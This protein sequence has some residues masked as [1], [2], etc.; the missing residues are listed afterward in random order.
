MSAHAPHSPATTSPQRTVITGLGVLCGVGIGLEPVWDG[1]VNGR[2]GIHPLHGAEFD[3]VAVKIGGTV[4]GFDPAPWIDPKEMR[5]VDAG[6]VYGLAAAQMAW[7]DAGL[8]Q[9]AAR[10]RWNPDRAGVAW[11]TAIGGIEWLERSVIDRVHGRRLSPF[12]VAGILPNMTAGN[13]SI[14]LGLRGPSICQATACAASSHA[15]GLAR[16]MINAGIADVMVVGGAEKVATPL[17]IAA[18]AAMRALSQRN[19]DPGRA[20]RPWDRGRDGFV[21]GDGGAVLILESEAHAR[22]RGARIYAELVGFGLSSDAH[23]ITSP[24]SDGVGAARAMRMALD[25]AH[26]PAEAIDYVNAH[27]TST[28]VGDLAEVAG[29]KAVFGHRARHTPVSSTKSMTGHLLGASGALEAVFSVLA[30]CR[31]VLP[32]TINLDQPDDGCDLDF[33]PHAARDKRVRRVLSNSFG[34]GGTNSALI[35]QNY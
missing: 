2:S 28:P 9:E 24:C 27:G 32:P 13:V 6:V 29:L 15:I 22:R 35:F 11:G 5:R 26:L 16:M 25:D 20:S 17:T 31:Q 23:H 18:H 12:F 4:P 10:E 21:L 8:D 1:I 14:A 7:A 30:L 34:F 3:D 33:V 19:D